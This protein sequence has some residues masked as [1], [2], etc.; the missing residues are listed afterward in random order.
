MGA[1]SYVLFQQYVFCPAIIKIT[2]PDDE[3]KSGEFQVSEVWFNKC[4]LHQSLHSIKI[5]GEAASADI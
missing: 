5:V 2:K 3:H 1:K 4:E